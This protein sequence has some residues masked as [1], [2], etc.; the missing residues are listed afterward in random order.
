MPTTLLIDPLVMMR[1]RQYRQ[2]PRAFQ[3]AGYDVELSDRPQAMGPDRNV[4]RF[5]NRTERLVNPQEPARVWGG[6]PVTHTGYILPYGRGG[7]RHGFD[8][9]GSCG[10]G[11]EPDQGLPFTALVLLLGMGGV[12]VYTLLQAP[13]S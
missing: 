4:R 2:A 10:M 12:L 13:R 7:Y 8:G 5:E 9:C 6:K 11:A 1:L 3:R